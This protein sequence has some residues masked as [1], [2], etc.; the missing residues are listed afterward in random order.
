MSELDS[1]C[2]AAVHANKCKVFEVALHMS[3][4]AQLGYAAPELCTEVLEQ[5][6]VLAAQH[7]VDVGSRIALVWAMRLLSI[8]PGTV[9]CAQQERALYDLA[10]G[11]GVPDTSLVQLFQVR[12]LRCV[13]VVV[14]PDSSLAPATVDSLLFYVLWSK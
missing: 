13:S 12:R 8:R 2:A 10:P 1:A 5:D 4:F 6:G 14:S 7:R 3:A 9:L 11:H